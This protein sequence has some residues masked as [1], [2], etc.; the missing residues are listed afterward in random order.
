MKK[1]DTLHL[2]YPIDETT[3]RY[4]VDIG[5][6]YYAEMFNGWDAS[7]LKRRDLEPE[8]ITY[9]E[10]VGLDIPLKEQLQIN[11]L[12]P[13]IKRQEEAEI[14]TVAAMKNH[15]KSIAYYIN[16]SMISNSRKIVIFLISSMSFIS[17]NYLFRNSDI[18]IFFNIFL[19][20]L[21]VGGWFLLWN[22][23]SIFIFD[24]YELKK[25]RRI[26]ERYQD[27]PIVFKDVL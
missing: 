8:L 13:N 22:A 17:V 18:S 16:R 3:K 7:P 5:I 25:K 2:I 24:N 27:T 20:G 1:K 23:F 12:I 9:L 14:R 11:I 26:F 10:Q 6:D 4:Q 21:F 15:F 19:E